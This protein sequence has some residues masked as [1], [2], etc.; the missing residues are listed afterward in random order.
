MSDT[1]AVVEKFIKHIE[2]QEYVEGFSL[3]ADDGTYTVIGNTKAS[4][5]YRGPNDLLTRLGALLGGF[6]EPPKLKFQPPLVDGDRAALFASGKGVGAHGPYNQPYYAF[7]VQV[8]DGKI[9]SM[10]EYFD[11]AELEVA[12][13]GKK[14]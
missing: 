14:L 3:L 6:K 5:V 1:R 11:T 9:Q 2:N 8:R 12:M 4:G 13:F 10:V 7:Q